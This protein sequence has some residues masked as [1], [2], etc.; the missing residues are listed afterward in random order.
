MVLPPRSHCIGAH[1]E[2]AE[3]YELGAGKKEIP[4]LGQKVDF[5]ILKN[6]S[7][8]YY[9][10]SISISKYGQIEARFKIRVESAE[11]DR[12]RKD[13]TG[14]ETPLGSGFF[15]TL[16]VRNIEIM[17]IM[18]SLE[19]NPIMIDEDNDEDGEDVKNEDD[20]VSE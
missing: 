16:A 15:I 6:S 18:E 3:D 8:Y 2:I 5:Q 10:N 13:L 11:L 19:K 9:E 12:I 14:L 1:I 7:G 4:H 17:E 20:D